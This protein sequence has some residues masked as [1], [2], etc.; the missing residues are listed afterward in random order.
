MERTN[1]Y[2]SDTDEQVMQKVLSSISS[3]I[4]SE[5]KYDDILLKRYQEM[6][7]QCNW[8]YPD[9]P[10]DNGCAV[11]YIDA[12]QDYQDYSILGFDIPTLIRTDHDKPISNIV[13]VVSQDPRRTERYKGKLS[14][15]SPFGFHD[16]SYRTNTRKGFMTPV[17]LQALEAAPGTA[18]YMTDCNKL[19][20]KDKRGIQKTDTHKY[21]E[22]LQKEIELIKLSCIIAH[23]RTANAI[24]GKIEVSI[25]CELHYVP[26]IGNSYIKKKDRENA[27][28]DFVHAFKNE[29]NK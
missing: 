19:F 14:L 25:N 6:K 2:I 8:E 17:I 4:F 21:Q 23:G 27:I 28:I 18:I 10:S 26:Y 7:E 5:K 1:I 15:S 3:V 29:N 24:L 12:P 9:G 16:K 20:T 11:K 22:I 13:M